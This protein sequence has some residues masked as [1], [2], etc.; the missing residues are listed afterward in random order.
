M[1][2]Y[3]RSMMANSFPHTDKNGRN[4]IMRQLDKDIKSLEFRFKKFER[5]KEDLLPEKNAKEKL[6]HIF[7]K[8]N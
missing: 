4:R 8:K 6:R 7:R 2:D 1:L 3:K 5:S